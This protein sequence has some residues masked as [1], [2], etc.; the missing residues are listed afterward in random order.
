MRSDIA[1]M[2]DMLNAAQKLQRFT[3]ALDQQSFQE[4]ELVQSAA[5]RELQVIGEAARLIT[6][7]TKQQY[8]QINWH[9]ISGMRNRLIH[10]YFDISYDIVWETIRQNIPALIMQL[11]PLIPPPS[12]APTENDKPN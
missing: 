10:E 12:E 7:E 1:L 3:Q 11:E 8:P 6:A 5:V 2:L 4:D 9:A